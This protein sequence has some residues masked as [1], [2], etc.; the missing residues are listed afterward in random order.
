MSATI[1]NPYF[2]NFSDDA[3]HVL[4]DLSV[5]H[6]KGENGGLKHFLLETLRW[7]GTQ[8]DFPLRFTYLVSPKFHGEL[9][10][11]Q[12]P[13][14]R[15]VSVRRSGEPLAELP[16]TWRTGD[17]LFWPPPLDLA[18]QV[19]ADVVYAPMISMEFACPGIPTV[20]FVA[21]VL[22]RDF[23][24]SCRADEL[25]RREEQFQEIIQISNRIQCISQ[26][27]MDRLHLHYPASRGRTFFTHVAIHDRLGDNTS[28][29]APA[30]LPTGPFFFYPA[31]A[32]GHKNHEGLLAAY[33]AYRL[34]AAAPLWELVLTGNHDERMD[35]ILRLARFLEIDQHVHYLGYLSSE[36]LSYVWQ[37]AGALVFPSRYEGFGI[38]P[39]EAMHYEIPVVSSQDASLPEVIGDAGLMF[40]PAEPGQFAGALEQIAGSA[41]LRS[42]L[43]TRGRNR[44]IG[45]SIAAES[46]KLLAALRS[47]AREPAESFWRGAD[48]MGVLEDRF[49]VGLPPRHGASEVAI[50]FAVPDYPGRVRL[51]QELEPLGSFLVPADAPPTLRVLIAAHART[52]IIEPIETPNPVVGEPPQQLVLKEIILSAAKGQGEP[53]GLFYSQ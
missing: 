48:K 33:R 46:A 23:P 36:E 12:R 49:V 18:L 32:W 7:L 52:L 45:F 2:H 8:T 9:K 27:G 15:I 6:P 35:R 20:G 11:I 50:T 34:Q 19:K 13:G 4:V 26:F 43:V 53:I 5:L 22:H 29:L 24:A 38:P 51:Y 1:F 31:N 30:G 16:G 37:Q 17:Y 39:T 10:S 28:K 3:L 47:A 21:D 14:D 44:L 41:Q 25:E 42:D 40:N